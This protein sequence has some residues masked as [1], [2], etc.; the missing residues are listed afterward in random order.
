MSLYS[1]DYI[2]KVNSPLK[3]QAGLGSSSIVLLLIIYLLPLDILNSTYGSLFPIK[4]AL[5]NYLANGAKTLKTPGN[6]G[7]AAYASFSFLN[8]SYSSYYYLAMSSY[9]FLGYY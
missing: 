3:F 6:F 4:S 9:K 2:S 8:L 7:I 5:I 1:C